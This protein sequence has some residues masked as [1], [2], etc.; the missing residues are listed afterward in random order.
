MKL[1]EDLSNNAISKEGGHLRVRSSRKTYQVIQVPCLVEIVDVIVCSISSACLSGV[2]QF[3]AVCLLEVDFPKRLGSLIQ[4]CGF[5]D[6][7]SG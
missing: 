4:R 6:Y 3:P 1:F 5:S 7:L 2:V